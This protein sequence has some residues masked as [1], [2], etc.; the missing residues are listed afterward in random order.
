MTLTPYERTRKAFSHEAPD[1]IPMDFNAAT[2]VLN[3]LYSH[4]GINDNEELLKI[5]KIDKRIVAPKYVG[6]PLKNFED[7]SHEIIVSG[8]PH[9][10]RIDDAGYTESCVHFPWDDVENNEDLE[11]R[12]GWNGKIEWWDFSNVKHDIDRLEA[13]DQYW[14]AVHGDPSGLQHL[15]MWVG[16]E[17]FYSILASDEDLAFAM[18]E[19]HN[20]YRLEYALKVLEAGGGRIHELMGGGDY[21]AQEGL[22][23]SKN[24]FNKFFRPLYKKFYSEIKKNFDVEIFFHCCG[25]VVDLIPDLIELGVTILDPIQTSARGME[26]SSLKNNYGNKLNFHGAIDIQQFLPNATEEEVRIEVKKVIS[27]LGKDGGYML[28]PGHAIQADTPIGNIIAMYDE[29]NRIKL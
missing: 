9:W 25:S 13:D 29:A 24:M 2:V 20:K 27:I 16:D 8:G 19:Q 22:L 11:G 4:F 12:Y 3:K 10:K 1:R 14:I 7:G 5:L 15:C 26:I 18:I 23:I 28:A 17:K 6:P 21:G